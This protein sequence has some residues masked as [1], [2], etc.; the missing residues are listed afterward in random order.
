[1]IKRLVCLASSTGILCLVRGKSNLL[2]RRIYSRTVEKSTGLRCDQTIAL[3]MPK[4]KRDYPQYLQRIKFYDAK[5]NK[6]LVFLTN[7]F[8][9]PALTIAELYRC[10]WKVES[11]IVFLSGSNSIS[12]N[13]VKTQI[14]FA[15]AVYGLVVFV[16]KRLKIVASLYTILQIFSLNLFN[17]TTLDQLLKNM[18]AQ[19]NMKKIT[20]I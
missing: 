19:R 13:V 15:F 18:E 14:W 2:F 3:T 10:R 17:K 7:N 9:L 8:D 4:A 11:S 12:E 1:M 6:S 20:T 5:H 16:K